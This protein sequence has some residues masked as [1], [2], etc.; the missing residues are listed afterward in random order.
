MTVYNL[1]VELEPIFQYVE[2][3]FGV[4]PVFKEFRGTAVAP[5]G[6]NITYVAHDVLDMG[7]VFFCVDRYINGSLRK[8]WAH[9]PL[10]PERIRIGF[11]EYAVNLLPPEPPNLNATIRIEPDGSWRINATVRVGNITVVAVGWITPGDRYRPTRITVTIHVFGVAPVYRGYGSISMSVS[12]ENV[13]GF[14]VKYTGD[15]LTITM[16]REYVHGNPVRI[17][18]EPIGLVIE[19]P[20]S[21]TQSFRKQQKETTSSYS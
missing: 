18:I 6:T 21:T 19:I 1:T 12:C 11:V 3:E 4:V 8:C 10:E 5:D 13:E 15:R 9:Q 14:S 17:T 20:I 16:D 7:T 2:T